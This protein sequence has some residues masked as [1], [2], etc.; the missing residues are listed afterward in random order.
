MYVGDTLYWLT[1]GDMACLVRLCVESEL[2]LFLQ[3]IKHS[4]KPQ[5]EENRYDVN[6]QMS[7]EKDQLPPELSALF[8][9]PF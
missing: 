4:L 2:L 9:G 5:L 6:L 3:K 7:T 8:D 1:L